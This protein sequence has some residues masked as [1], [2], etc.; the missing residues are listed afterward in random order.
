ML[1][2]GLTGGV[3]SGK[4]T[5]SQTLKEEGAHLVDAD[6]IARELVK[7]E[8]PVWRALVSAFGT[9][10]LEADGSIHR[11]RLRAIVFAD[12][13]QRDL[14]NE[15][16]HPPIRAEIARCV[17]EIGERDPETIVVVDAALLVETGAY[18]EMDKLIVVTSRESQQLERMKE[19]DGV[20]EEQARRVL[21]SQMALEEK[22]RVADYVIR[23]EGS[24]DE[25]RRR[26]K[27]VFQELKRIAA[28]ERGRHRLRGTKTSRP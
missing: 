15:I 11:R 5:V 14:L 12:P 24:L 13:E 2:V 25:T 22:L 4:T 19:R 9:D 26:T 17:K 16:L 7:P 28:H 6:R 20:S 3:A 10:I 1:V 21:S 18:Q 27:K 23:N 8:T